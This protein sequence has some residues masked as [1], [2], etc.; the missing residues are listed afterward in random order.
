MLLDGLGEC[1]YPGNRS[2]S[3]VLVMFLPFVPR[4][5]DLPGD[6]ALTI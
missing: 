1:S 3:M 6:A 4:P 2:A 5:G